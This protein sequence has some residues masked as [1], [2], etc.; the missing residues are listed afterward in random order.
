MRARHSDQHNVTSR[1]Q[2]S[3]S[4]ACQGENLSHAAPSASLQASAPHHD[5]RRT[6]ILI[7]WCHSLAGVVVI[8]RTCKIINKT[9]PLRLHTLPRSKL[10]LHLHKTSPLESATHSRPI[11]TTSISRPIKNQKR[12]AVVAVIDAAGAV[13]AN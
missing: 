4:R 13:C 3:E 12:L 2:K 8:R 5:T 10:S 11:T 1:E 7:A 9:L 6:A